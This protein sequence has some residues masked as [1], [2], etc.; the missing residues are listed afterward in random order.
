MD[1]QSKAKTELGI[2]EG[3]SEKV[4]Q[5]STGKN[6]TSG[7]V[8]SN[9]QGKNMKTQDQKIHPQCKDGAN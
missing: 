6:P 1:G 4:V 8:H 2:L 5:N 9:G 3:K 7:R